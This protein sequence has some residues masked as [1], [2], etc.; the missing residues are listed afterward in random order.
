MKLWAEGTVER[1][2][3]AFLSHVVF[4]CPV[5]SHPQAWY[6]DWGRSLSFEKVTVSLGD[7]MMGK[8]Q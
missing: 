8:P 6:R 7:E 5:G 2:I 3:C 4:E 1:V